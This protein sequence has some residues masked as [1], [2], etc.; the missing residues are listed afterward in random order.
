LLFLVSE[1]S[2]ET[3]RDFNLDVLIIDGDTINKGISTIESAAE[4][5]GV[6][7]EAL[8][9]EDQKTE[10]GNP[11]F[12]WN[13]NFPGDIVVIPGGQIE[14][15]GIFTLPSN[16]PWSL[17]DFVDGTVNKDQLD[18]I[19]NV[20]PLRNPG[21][22]ALVGGRFAAVVYDSDISINYDPLNANLQGSRYGLFFFTVLEVI[23]PGSLSESGSSDS[24][25]DLKI[26]VDV[27]PLNDDTPPVVTFD[28]LPDPNAA[29]WN[30]EPVTISFDAT[31]DLSGIDMIDPDIL[32][33]TEGG[34]QSFVGTATDIARNVGS[35]AAIVNID[36]TN[37]ELSATIT[38]TPNAFGWVNQDATVIF[39]ATDNL[40][41]IGDV[42][43]PV[44]VSVEGEGQIRNGS[45]SDLAE[46]IA[47]LEVTVNI[48]KTNPT[49]SFAIPQD[50]AIFNNASPVFN[51]VY[52][53]SLS[54]INTSATI[55]KIDGTPQTTAFF[56]TE[57]IFIFS[58]PD[59][60]SDGTHPLEVIVQDFAQNS[61]S[62]S[63]SFIIDTTGNVF[64]RK[65]D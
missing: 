33:T 1:V 42:T 32:V 61:A 48:D 54:G 5:H 63:A 51:G 59:A 16:L 26:R 14:D 36:F 4:S 46:N 17:Q 55:I 62:D 49:V 34:N 64:N 35:V 2:A 20:Q 12:Y 37:P 7:T 24:L 53:D 6:K 57:S 9:N 47:N 27:N 56:V 43:S 23:P 58:T 44:V 22:Q 52:A 39:N 40:S 29:G 28:I 31:D 21:L 10:D 15:E 8:V 30:N 25:F 50:G 3:L 60:L 38:P 11:V 45:T 19:A 18:K 13:D 41:G 65:S